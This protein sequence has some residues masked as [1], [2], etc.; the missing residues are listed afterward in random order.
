M[1]HNRPIPLYHWR[2]SANDFGR[3]SPRKRSLNGDLAIMTREQWRTKCRRRPRRGGI[4][5]SSHAVDSVG[6]ERR[7]SPPPRLGA[8]LTFRL[9]LPYQM[10]RT[11]RRRR[12]LPFDSHRVHRM[13]TTKGFRASAWP[14]STLRTPLFARHSRQITTR[15]AFS[16]TQATEVIGAERAYRL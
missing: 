13:T 9:S 2:A 6:V 4:L 14:P 7:V 3:L 8:M 10:T 1:L 5:R 15:T 12:Y 11:V 16:R